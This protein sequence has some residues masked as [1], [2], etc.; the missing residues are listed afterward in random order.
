MIKK[1][2]EHFEY[3]KARKILV[4]SLMNDCYSC[5]A[6][7]KDLLKKTAAVVDMADSDEYK[8][9]LKSINKLANYMETPPASEETDM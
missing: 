1:I 4:L 8:A 2:K 9:A 6:V 3:R 7:I 5:I